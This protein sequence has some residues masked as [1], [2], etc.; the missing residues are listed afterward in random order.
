MKWEWVEGAQVKEGT[1]RRKPLRYL[2]LPFT[3]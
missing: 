1:V 2:L 3:L